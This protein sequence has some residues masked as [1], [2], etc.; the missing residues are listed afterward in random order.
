MTGP[1]QRFHCLA[2]QQIDLPVQPQMPFD[3]PGGGSVGMINL[4]EPVRVHVSAMGPLGRKRTAGIDAGWLTVF[5]GM[6]HVERELADMNAAWAAAGK[7]PTTQY[8][9]CFGWGCVLEP[10]GK[11][12]LRLANSMR[13]PAGISIFGSLRRGP[14][15]A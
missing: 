13:V 12:A 7:D 15:H 6:G 11:P 5:T 4:G 10:G 9:T 2:L 14:R 3:L 1:L 8:S